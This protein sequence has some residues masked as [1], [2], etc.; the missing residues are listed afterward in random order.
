MHPSRGQV[1]YPKFPS[2][3]ESQLLINARE[4]A[5]V[6]MLMK[7][8]LYFGLQGQH[9]QLFDVLFGIRGQRVVQRAPRWPPLTAAEV[10][11][12]A[13]YGLNGILLTVAV[14]EVLVIVL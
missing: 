13:P 11:P 2:A 12:A 8:V 14:K 6:Q 3:Q 1:N 4:C 9:R 10:F 7:E 5:R